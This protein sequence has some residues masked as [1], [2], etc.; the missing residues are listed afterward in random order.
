MNERGQ[1]C[2]FSRS[3]LDSFLRLRPIVGIPTSYLDTCLEDVGLQ[4]RTSAYLRINAQI[5]T[6]PDTREMTDEDFAHA[7]VGAAMPPLVIS[8]AG[9][10]II[11][12]F[13][14]IGFI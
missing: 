4:G 9:I 5:S 10:Y 3:R 7:K 14:S 8:V 13:G 6:D 2:T 12:C 1:V 11:I